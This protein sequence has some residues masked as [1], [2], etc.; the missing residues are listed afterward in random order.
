[1]KIVILDAYTSNPGDLS[2][3]GLKE[4]GTL[5]ILDRVKHNPEVISEA[6]GDAE[7][8][9]TN[10][11]PISEAVLKQAS[12][13]KYIGVLATGYNVVD[14]KCAQK[15]GITVTNIP[16]YSTQSVAQFTMGLLLEMCHHI[17]D[18]SNSVHQGD[19]E[20]SLDF[21]YW[22]SPLIELA[23]KKF[24]IIGM[25]A[26]GQ[27]TAQLALA[28]GMEVIF[29]NRSNKPEAEKE[30]CR[31][32]PLDQLLAESDFI[33]LHSPLTPETEHLINQD[34]ISKMKD[35]VK[36][37]NTS[38]GPLI[39]EQDLYEALESGK[40]SGA[41]VDV[42]SVEPIKGDNPLL[43]AKNCIITPHIAWAPWE[44]RKRL[45]Q[46]ATDNLKAFQEGKAVNVVS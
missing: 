23:G 10:K 11:T 7:A 17:G 28:F 24:G 45:I 18:H 13:L 6:I 25:G 41:A 21:S 34:S 39:H 12:K 19:W 15:L 5:K 27:A 30:N 31:Q 20:R 44:G 32:V 1:M 3:D 8:I 29:H 2:W 33:S 37:I 42:V 26:I 36:L 4:L 35:G 9:L 40:I 38:R 22:N 46:I 14:I 16:S 43:K